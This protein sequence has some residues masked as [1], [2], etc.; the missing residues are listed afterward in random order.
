M[1]A[2]FR[3]LGN[4]SVDAEPLR[5]AVEGGGRSLAS[6]HRQRARQP[7]RLRRQRADGPPILRRPIADRRRHPDEL[8]RRDGEG[9]RQAGTVSEPLGLAVA[10]ACAARVPALG[11][12]GR[13]LPVR[14]VAWPDLLPSMAPRGRWAASGT[15]GFAIRYPHHILHKI[16]ADTASAWPVPRDMLIGLLFRPPLQDRPQPRLTGCG[17]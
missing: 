11:G 1:A 3:R 7:S 6:A 8:R 9:L 15:R 16:Q 5:L 4:A 12:E 10:D 14:K 2:L 17:G 13:G